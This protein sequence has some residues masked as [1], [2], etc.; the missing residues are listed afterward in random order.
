MVK[1]GPAPRDAVS[2]NALATLF[3]GMGGSAHT[4]AGGGFVFAS[5]MQ[6]QGLPAGQDGLTVLSGVAP[7]AYE[8]SARLGSA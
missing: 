2:G 3:A 1:H 4:G 5:M 7:G 8:I 6:F